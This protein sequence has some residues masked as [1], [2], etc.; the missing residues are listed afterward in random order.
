M[1]SPTPSEPCPGLV[2]KRTVC[3]CHIRPMRPILLPSNLPRGLE[4][5]WRPLLLVDRPQGHDW[6]SSN[7][8]QSWTPSMNRFSSRLSLLFVMKLDPLKYAKKSTLQL[9]PPVVSGSPEVDTERTKG[10]CEPAWHSPQQGHKEHFKT[11][12][13]K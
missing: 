1:A 4:N 6:T 10:L 5:P 2:P 13:L 3:Q 11:A 7:A 8:R 12:R 9:S